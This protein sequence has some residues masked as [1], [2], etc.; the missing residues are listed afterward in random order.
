MLEGGQ[1]RQKDLAVLPRGQLIRGGMDAIARKAITE[2]MYYFGAAIRKARKVQMY[3][4]EA[5]YYKF[6]TLYMEGDFQ[7]AVNRLVEC[8]DGVKLVT[9]A[10]RAQGVN[11]P[12]EALADRLMACLAQTMVMRRDSLVA[13]VGHFWQAHMGEY[14]LLKRPMTLVAAILK[15]W[16][17]INTSTRVSFDGLGEDVKPYTKFLQDQLDTAKDMIEEMPDEDGAVGETDAGSSG[18]RGATRPADREADAAKNREKAYVGF[19]KQVQETTIMGLSPA[20]IDEL[21]ELCRQSRNVTNLGSVARII[22][23]LGP[24]SKKSY[25]AALAENDLMQSG[26]A[27][28]ADKDAERLHVEVLEYM[29][30]Q[31]EG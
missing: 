28:L 6:V 24:N 10:A 4:V 11:L 22:D 21:H 12:Q 1:E 2:A 9:D 3:D 5:E 15:T 30:K 31:S 14:F 25:L 13:L 19:L 27:R 26:E 7:G 23:Q 29:A 18:G 17:V 8:L 16:L 20:Q